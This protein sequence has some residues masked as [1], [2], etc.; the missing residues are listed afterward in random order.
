MLEGTLLDGS[1]D[2]ILEGILVEGI[3]E[4]S[5]LDGIIV[6]ILEGMFDEGRLLDGSDDGYKLIV[7]VNVE[8]KILFPF[9]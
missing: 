7:G 1:D 5:L 8:D 9:L 2:G 6:G 3:L 4:G